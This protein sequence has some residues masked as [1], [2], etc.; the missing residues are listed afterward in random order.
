RRGRHWL[1]RAPP[2]RRV[3]AR[4]ARSDQ[5]RGTRVRAIGHP[6]ER[7]VPRQHR[8]AHDAR[9]HR[10]RSRDRADDEGDVADRRARPPRADR[11]GRR[12]AVLRQRVVRER[13]V[14]AGL[15]RLRLPVTSAR[16]M[17]FRVMTEPQEGASY[18][19]L[20]AVA[21]LAEEGGFD[22]FF[23]SDHYVGFG[24]GSHLPGP[25]DAWTT[26]AGLARETSTVRLG[27]L[28]SPVTFR[29]PGQLALVVAQVDAMSG[30]RIE[31]GVGAGWNEAEHEAHAIPYPPTGE[32][33]DRLEEQLAILRGFWTAP[34]GGRFSFTGRHY[35]VADSPALPKPVQQ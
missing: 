1:P 8:H 9:R 28:V 25:T 24:P 15:R 12:V 30:G 32:R 17:R 4:R 16:A 35:R 13:G 18:D 2:L 14:D 29:F 5:D 22:G 33:F 23:R 27:T 6:R 31:L 19:D 34:A 10:R 3:E 11:R 7:G 26:L 21:R 20:L